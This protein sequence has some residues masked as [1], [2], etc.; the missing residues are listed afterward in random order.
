VGAYVILYNSKKNECQREL[1][2]CL[3]LFLINGTIGEAWENSYSDGSILVA[4]IS[5]LNS[6]HFTSRAITE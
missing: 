4:S 5:G 3:F 6:G 1:L 2:L